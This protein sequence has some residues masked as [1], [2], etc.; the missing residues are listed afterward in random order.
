ME[1]KILFVVQKQ[2]EDPNEIQKPREKI[3][4]E[5]CNQSFLKQ[6]SLNTHLMER[7]KRHVKEVENK[8]LLEN[9]KENLLEEELKN[10]KNELYEANARGRALGSALK[11]LKSVQISLSSKGESKSQCYGYGDVAM[12]EEC[13]KVNAIGV[14]IKVGK[15]ISKATPG[16][17]PYFSV[18]VRIYTPF[19]KIRTICIKTFDQFLLPADIAKGRVL[20]IKNGFK[21][22]VERNGN[23]SERIVVIPYF[24]TFD[25][26][27]RSSLGTLSALFKHK[28]KT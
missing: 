28:R 9:L 25:T 15:V 2:A 6:S 19:K 12:P 14:I 13:G 21:R 7:H 22:V 20:I 24:S 17:F 3:Q 27:P 4:C 18:Y 1:E 8:E 26:Y 10:L 5:L 11:S 23:K 16:H